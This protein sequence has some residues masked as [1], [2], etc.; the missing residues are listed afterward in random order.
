MFCVDGEYYDLSG[1]QLSVQQG[2]GRVVYVTEDGFDPVDDLDDE[3]A[4]MAS[5]EDVDIRNKSSWNIEVAIEQCWLLLDGCGRKA[6]RL[7]PVSTG[8]VNRERCLGKVE[9]GQSP[10]ERHYEQL[11]PSLW[12][13][14][15]LKR[16][17]N[18]SGQACLTFRVEDDENN[19]Q[20]PYFI[21]TL[22]DSHPSVL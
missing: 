3:R 1:R 17:I 21:Q 14:R 7:M 6:S 13:Q 10:A 2:R 8:R 22:A 19:S 4:E 9:T 5:W 20:P 18:S 12:F 15:L 16:V 11:L